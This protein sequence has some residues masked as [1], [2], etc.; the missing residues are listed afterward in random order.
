MND[1]LKILLEMLFNVAY[2]MI[3]WSLVFK[4]FLKKAKVS[5]KNCKLAHPLIWM[6]GLLAL[7]DTGHVGF[8]VIA[9][10]TDGLPANSSLIG[11]GKLATSITVTFFYILLIKVW[12]LR[13]DQKYNFFTDLLFGCA[14]VRLVIMVLPGNEWLSVAAPY[15]WVI[16]RNI[17]LAISGLGIAYLILKNALQTKDRAFIWVA[18]MIFISYGF[19]IPV[20]L[21][22]NQIP[23]IGLLMIP[24]TLAYLAVAYIVYY[25]I[26]KSTNSTSQEEI[27]C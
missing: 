17:P 8:R 22:A 26:F 14:L 27:P 4:M 23:A 13:Y 3:I 19:Y 6:F 5:V 21:L 11:I 20:I 25:A 18:I 24:K 12:K 16:Y 15:K 7:G 10:L 9:Y 2:L 1:Q